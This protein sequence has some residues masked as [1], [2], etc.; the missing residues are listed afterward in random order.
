MPR[1]VTAAGP[2]I[3]ARREHT[4]AGGEWVRPVVAAVLLALLFGVPHHRLFLWLSDSLAV[5]YWKELLFA[6]GLLAYGSVLVRRRLTGAELRG[7]MWA[8][9]FVLAVLVRLGVGVARGESPHLLLVGGGSHLYYVPVFLLAIHLLETSHRSPYR[10]VERALHLILV[11]TSLAAVLSVADNVYHLSGRF[12]FF[13]RSR[14]E[15]TLDYGSG[16]WRSSATY[17]SPMHLGMI[18]GTGFLVALFLFVTRLGDR[19][20]SWARLAGPGALMLLHLVGLYLTFSRGPLVATAAGAAVVGPFARRGLGWRR[21]AGRW[22]RLAVGALVAGLLL[23]LA[24]VLLPPALQ[25]HVGSIFDWSGDQNNSTRLRR[26][27]MG[28]ERIREDPWLGQGLGSAQ[29]RL[30]NYRFEELGREFFF[31]NP[32]SQLL[33]WGVEGGLV[34]VLSALLVV[35]FM[36]RTSLAMASR[37]AGSELQRLGVLF[38]GLQAALY[39]EGLVMTI[40]DN[41]T[42]QIGFWVLFGT[43]VHFRSE[44]DVGSVEASRPRG[45]DGDT[46]RAA[47][48]SGR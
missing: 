44:I 34:L 16:V 6:A 10:T 8:A 15:S 42:F 5:K 32:E 12:D 25:Q 38:L 1:G 30:A 21:L 40:L 23:V 4:V 3:V 28:V 48:R 18:T 9:P 47:A 17:Q 19:P 41:R 43:L 27:A 26:M 31:T 24:Y 36:V 29:A 35:G 37:P 11:A 20:R 7:V 39:A 2:R 33:S 14:V 13:G 46:R 45:E 22:R